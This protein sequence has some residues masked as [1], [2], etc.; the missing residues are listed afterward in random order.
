MPGLVKITTLG[1]TLRT[2][3]IHSF[4]NLF[5]FYW[6]FLEILWF[7]IFLFF[8][9]F[10][11]SSKLLL[12]CF[13]DGSWSLILKSYELKVIKKMFRNQNLWR[14]GFQVVLSHKRLW[15]SPGVD[16]V[17]LTFSLN[18]FICL[19]TCFILRVFFDR[20]VMN[21]SNYYV[22][23]S[24]FLPS[25][26]L[27]LRITMRTRTKERREIVKDYETHETHERKHF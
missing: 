19:L 2:L 27:S 1:I 4:Y 5:F 21:P 8:Y 23:S 13:W 12:Q 22:S 26:S 18:S 9:K 11:L 25:T 14:M 7:Y 15:K 6:H 20:C 10:F 3:E 16:L 17:F 24:W